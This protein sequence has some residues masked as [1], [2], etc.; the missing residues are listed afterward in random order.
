[1]IVREH[2][3]QQ[4]DSVHHPSIMMSI[5]ML[6][7][8]FLSAALLLSSAAHGQNAGGLRQQAEALKAKGDAAGALAVFEKAAAA[9]PKSADIE[10]Q[11]GF[12]LA[13]LK[14]APE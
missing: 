10:D 14:R 13:V 11:I 6:R 5:G 12:L 9:D 3:E 2:R 4:Q 7:R 1:M 8:S